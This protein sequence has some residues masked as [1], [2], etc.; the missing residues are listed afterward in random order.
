MNGT[1]KVFGILVLGSFVFLS[2]I[3]YMADNIDD[4]EAVPL[5][6]PK[7]KPIESH[8]PMIT[9]DATSRNKWTLVDFSTGETHSI[10]DLE[11]E[12]SKLND[13][14]WDLGFQRTKI[15]TNSGMTNPKGNVAVRNLGVIDFDSVSVAPAAGY[16]QDAKSYGKVINKAIADWYLY[17]T[18]THNVESQ[19]NVYAVR[20]AEGGYLK[21]RIL[22]Y[23]CKHEEAE[24]KM[25]MCGRQ[26]AA[27]YGI[28]YVLPKDNGRHFPPPVLTT[29]QASSDPP[30][31]ESIN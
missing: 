15:I 5:P 12:R 19:K 7:I 13:Y 30:S 6:P 23:Y 22:N 31:T 28:E 1:A 2:A 4:Y 25:I 16:T 20:M 17:R 3:N 29:P 21:M 26:E 11:K 27:C 14:P 24:C 10:N 18:R 8:N 9:I